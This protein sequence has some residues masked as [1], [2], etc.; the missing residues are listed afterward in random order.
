VRGTIWLVED[1]CNGSTFF[2]TRRGIV[3]VRDFVKHKSLP[4]PAGK[5]YLAGEE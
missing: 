3:E 1:R 4:L 2:K 5:T